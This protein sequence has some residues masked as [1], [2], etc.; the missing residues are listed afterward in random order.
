[1]SSQRRNFAVFLFVFPSWWHYVTSPLIAHDRWNLNTNTL[2][3]CVGKYV[4]LV[5]YSHV[6]WHF[7]ITR[8]RNRDKKGCLR[9]VYANVFGY[10]FGAA[11]VTVFVRCPY[12]FVSTLNEYTYFY[13]IMR[14]SSMTSFC[15]SACATVVIYPLGQLYQLI[16]HRISISS[17]L[18]F[19]GVGMVRIL[20]WYEFSFEAW[21]FL[22]R[23]DFTSML[24]LSHT[25]CQRIIKALTSSRWTPTLS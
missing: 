19:V 5:A 25:L 17:A 4:K 2:N 9:K 1:M 20:A 7:V 11:L 21:T 8:C 10:R 15:S 14:H 24:I 3:L 13:S 22:C 23:W 16:R 18:W 12:T 6:G